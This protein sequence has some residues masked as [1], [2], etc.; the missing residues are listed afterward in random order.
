MGRSWYGGRE[1]EGDE[2]EKE[3]TKDGDEMWRAERGGKGAKA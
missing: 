1:R 3:R 2:V